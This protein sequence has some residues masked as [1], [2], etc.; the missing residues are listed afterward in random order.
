[1]EQNT[2]R[3]A[4][5]PVEVRREGSGWPLEMRALEMRVSAWSIHLGP[6]AE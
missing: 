1:M 4:A 6:V 2:P 3:G 5:R